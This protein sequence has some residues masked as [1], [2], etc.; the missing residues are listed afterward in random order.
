CVAGMCTCAGHGETA[1]Q[2]GGRCTT[3]QNDPLNCGA[4]GTMCPGNTY[5]CTA[6]KCTC[7]PGFSLCKIGPTNGCMDLQ[8]SLQNCGACGFACTGSNQRCN[9]GMCV[10]LLCQQM[11]EVNC[12]NGCY[13]MAE[14][15]KDPLNCGMCNNPCA[16]DQVCVAG[17]C[18]SYTTPPCS[19]C[20]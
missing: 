4:C 20:P 19:S 15:Q 18:Q 11:G 17:Q 5:D 12:N 6:G 14:L 8:H 1:T 2:C 7:R 9:K 13:T 10:T 16:V 3:T